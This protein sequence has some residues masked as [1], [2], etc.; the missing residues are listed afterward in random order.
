MIKHLTSIRLHPSKPTFMRTLQA[1]LILCALLLIALMPVWGQTLARPTYNAPNYQFEYSPTWVIN[2]EA[3]YISQARLHTFWE[4]GDGLYGFSTT[5]ATSGSPVTTATHAYSSGTGVSPTENL[6][7]S[8]LGHGIYSITH[9]PPRANA[10]SMPYIQA[11]SYMVDYSAISNLR[12]GYDLSWNGRTTTDEQF[13]IVLLYKD[14][15]NSGVQSGSVELL[16]NDRYINPTSTPATFRSRNGETLTTSGARIASPYN[17]RLIWKFDSLGDGEERAIFIDMRVNKTM[18][19]PSGNRYQFEVAIITPN[20]VSQNTTSSRSAVSYSNSIGVSLDPNYIEF[21]PSSVLRGS[22]SQQVNCKVHFENI[23]EI[24]VN[25][26]QIALPIDSAI[27]AYSVSNMYYVRDDGSE[28][29]T[30]FHAIET[31]EILTVKINNAQLTGS[32]FSAT[33]SGGAIYFTA[34]TKPEKYALRDSLTGKATVTFA[35]VAPVETGE[36]VI[37]I[38]DESGNC[39]K[40]DNEI[41][42]IV[43]LILIIAGIIILILYFLARWLR[44]NRP[45]V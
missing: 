38:F 44:R 25:D 12:I 17:K 2:P 21:T 35:G 8:A 26:I 40:C 14:I 41:A 33:T 5:Y 16:Y 36:G 13:T 45:N 1:G 3:N 34:W 43:L 10:T 24:G 28:Y 19:A 30:L 18:P 6:T 32:E 23:G 27:D 37:N 7:V 29:Q 15:T 11:Q 9:Q 31:G 4:Y 20:L 39:E 22:P 42:L